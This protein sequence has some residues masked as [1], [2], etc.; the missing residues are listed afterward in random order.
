M[1]K[2]II[3]VKNLS[4]VFIRHKKMPGFAGSIKGLFKRERVETKAVDRTKAT[5]IAKQILDDLEVEDINID[6]PE[7]E[8]VIRE[9]F[10]DK[11]KS[12][13]KK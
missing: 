1:P 7:A 3:E 4:K 5:L 12:E 10:Q 9:V 13:S 8:E 11:V 6:E 2:T